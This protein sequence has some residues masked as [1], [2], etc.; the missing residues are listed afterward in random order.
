MNFRG[1]YRF[2]SVQSDSI[3]TDELSDSY[4]F[5]KPSDSLTDAVATAEA[6]GAAVRL[7][8]GLH[9]S[10][11]YPVTVPSGV[12]VEGPNM[13]SATPGGDVLPAVLDAGG[14][15]AFDC[16]AGEA[17]AKAITL[18][19]F[20][21]MP[22]T[23]R[24]SSD[25]NRDFLM[26]NIYVEGADSGVASGRGFEILN[27]AFL[28][29]VRNVHAEQCDGYGYY[30]E[31]GGQALVDGV[32]AFDCGDVTDGG[33]IYISDH[34]GG[35]GEGEYRRLVA[36][37]GDSAN[38][39]AQDGIVA[40]ALY[41]SDLYGVQLEKC[42][43]GLV[44]AETNG[45]SNGN[46][47]HGGRILSNNIGVQAGQTGT[48]T[49]GTYLDGVKFD[50]NS[51]MDIDLQGNAYRWHIGPCMEDSGG[52]QIGAFSVQNAGWENTID[53][54]N[55]SVPNATGE[56]LSTRAPVFA[57]EV[58]IHDGTGTMPRGPAIANSNDPSATTDWV[59]LIDGTSPS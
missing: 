20:A 28:Y 1:D 48:K 19:D 46:L 11:N 25:T 26:E 4:V 40:D 42:D 50:S 13:G 30:S 45:Q 43:R 2:R 7:S 18:R 53:P 5:V 49:Y 22:G 17:T 54:A 15:V 24:F 29:T 38:A 52:Q 35:G 36:G 58:A 6:T 32:R 27:T 57:N 37:I 21:V 9:D 3:S 34:G 33:Q 41:A 56:D 47:I 44:F 31:H 12:T 55:N 39:N 23:I 14:G 10:H 16:G 51:T 59:S 8:G